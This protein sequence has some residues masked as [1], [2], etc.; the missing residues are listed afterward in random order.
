[1]GSYLVN[2]IAYTFAMVG[3]I[4]I[5]LIVYKKC[6]VNSGVSAKPD[7]LK[8]ENALNLSARKTI[9]VIK[10]GDEKFLVASDVDKTTFL[11]K[12]EDDALKKED[13]FSKSSK[14]PVLAGISVGED[15]NSSSNVAKLP[16][17]KELLRKLNS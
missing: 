1:M 9:Y 12:L 17:M 3:L 5:C 4:C 7:F 2:F 8:I 16:V 11:A 13:K 10:A 6:F 15:L 14:K